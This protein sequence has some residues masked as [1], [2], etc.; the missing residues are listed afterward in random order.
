MKRFAAGSAL[1]AIRGLLQFA[2]AQLCPAP[3]LT[4]GIKLPRVKTDGIHTWSEDEI[5][6]YEARHAIGSMARLALAL[7]VY[8][9][10]RRGDVL[11]MGRQHIRDGVLHRAPGEDRHAADRSRCMPELQAIIDA[12]STAGQLT[13]LTTN[14]GRAYGAE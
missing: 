9:A 2:V 14:K 12:T 7:L 8:T 11:R 1:K 10:Q 3:T 13:L 4:Q 5:A 6:R